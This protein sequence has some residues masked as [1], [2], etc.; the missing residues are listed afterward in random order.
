MK[1]IIKTSVLLILI[2]FSVSSCFT[3]VLIEKSVPPEIILSKAKNSIAFINKYDYTLPDASRE[4]EQSVIRTGVTQVIEGLKTSLTY[5]EQIDLYIIDTLVTG[6]ALKNFSDTITADSVRD[7]CRNNNSSLL[8]VLET[9]DP[10]FDWD[11][12]VEEFDDGSKSRTNNFYLIIT[13]GLSLYSS[14]GELI[15]R[16]MI[17]RSE[18]YKSRTALTGIIAFTPSLAKA[19]D[20]VRIL[21]RMV[22]EDYT[23]K[24]YPATESVNRKILLGKDFLEVASYCHEGNW[25]KALELLKPLADSPDPGIARKAAHNLSVVYEAIGDDKASEYW[26]KISGE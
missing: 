20:D 10:R 5:N 14:V 25:G 26:M 3:Y 23:K 16:S 4:K 8:L 17:S 24:F 21:A 2:S 11:T 13:A 6:K 12:E 7:I 22:G 19:E 15:D 1:T 18:L 9:F